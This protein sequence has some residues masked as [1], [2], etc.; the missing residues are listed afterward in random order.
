MVLK[1]LCVSLPGFKENLEIKLIGNVD[2][3]VVREITTN[4][5]EEYLILPGYVSHQQAATLMKQSCVLLVVINHKSPN[6]KGI[7]TGKIFEYLATGRPVLAIG[8]TDGDL[9]KILED[10]EAGNIALYDDIDT[11]KSIVTAFY[12]RYLTNELGTNNK[13]INNYTR[14]FL[15]AKL[16]DVMN[17]LPILH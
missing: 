4:K 5:L 10:S 12:Q 14:R 2:A 13:K 6:A 8:P 1:D 9:A 7:L 17:K 11:I 3:N 16:A 15:T